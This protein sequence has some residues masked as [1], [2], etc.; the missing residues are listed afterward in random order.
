M[1]NFMYAQTPATVLMRPNTTHKHRTKQPDSS[2][3]KD[4]LGLEL[5]VKVTTSFA[6]GSSEGWASPH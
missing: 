3:Q 6:I 1:L 2:G 4:V 5:I